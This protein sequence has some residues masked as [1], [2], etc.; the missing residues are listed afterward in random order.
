VP[1]R[2]PL[3]REDHTAR[4]KGRGLG[5]LTE[6]IEEPLKA[7]S[8]VTEAMIFIGLHGYMP[9][10]SKIVPP[11]GL[12]VVGTLITTPRNTL[13]LIS[14]MDWLMGS[15]STSSAWEA[16]DRVAYSRGTG[17]RLSDGE[18]TPLQLS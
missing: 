15:E 18:P 13:I 10:V 1:W 2:G 6:M 9:S 4:G 8:S 11:R 3:P 14:Y 7:S 12:T 5:G 16:D 17:S